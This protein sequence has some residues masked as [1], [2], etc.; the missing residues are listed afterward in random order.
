MTR[1]VAGEGRLFPT[2][3]DGIFYFPIEG[4]VFKCKVQTTE[5]KFVGGGVVVFRLHAMPDAVG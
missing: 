3:D 4:I 1:G 5:G 2:L